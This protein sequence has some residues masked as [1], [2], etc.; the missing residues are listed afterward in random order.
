M[1]SRAIRPLALSLSLALSLA[2]ITLFLLPP[3]HALSS[4]GARAGGQT[5]QPR[6]DEQP[7][8]LPGNRR[9][10]LRAEFSVI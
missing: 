3:A 1:V 8:L 7:H 6:L 5:Y 4:R 9:K 2:I 10:M